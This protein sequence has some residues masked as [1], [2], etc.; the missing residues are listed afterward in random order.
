MIH[1]LCWVYPNAYYIVIKCPNTYNGLLLLSCP[2][3]SPQLTMVN[4]LCMTA[5]TA[6][7]VATG[8]YL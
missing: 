7:E 3:Y 6:S 4:L 2:L 8:L 1:C 5:D